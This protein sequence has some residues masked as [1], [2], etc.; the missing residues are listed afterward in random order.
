MPRRVWNRHAESG[1]FGS[2]GASVMVGSMGDVATRLKK[3]NPLMLSIHCIHHRLALGA[4]QSVE[5]V[6]YL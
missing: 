4:A 1:G 5:A 3:S 6:S 2:D